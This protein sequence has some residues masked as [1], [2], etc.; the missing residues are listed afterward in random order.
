M[1]MQQGDG[2]MLRQLREQAVTRQLSIASTVI[3]EKPYQDE[4]R[5]N[6]HKPCDTVF[7]CYSP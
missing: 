5:G 3:E 2:V 6:A 4:Q 7:H 1:A